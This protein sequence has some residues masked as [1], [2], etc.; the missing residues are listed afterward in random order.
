MPIG[1]GLLNKNRTKALAKTMLKLGAQM[2]V[3]YYFSLNFTH[4][5]SVLFYSSPVETETL[6]LPL[7]FSY[8]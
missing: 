2:C 7:S 5:V 1:Q 6:L 4:L 3:Y 8:L